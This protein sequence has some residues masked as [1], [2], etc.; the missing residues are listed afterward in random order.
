MQPKTILLGIVYYGYSSLNA[1]YLFVTDTITTS[2]ITE[3]P[4]RQM[5]ASCR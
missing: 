4:N 2:T 5:R 3:P 1:V